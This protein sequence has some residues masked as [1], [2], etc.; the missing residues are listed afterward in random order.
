MTSVVGGLDVAFSNDYMALVLVEQGNDGK[1]RLKHLDMWRQFDWQDWKHSM[2]AKMEKYFIYKIY[3]DKTNNQS[4]TF[5]LDELGIPVHGV[6]F[7]SGAK[8]DMIRNVIK[9]INTE[10]LIMPKVETIS[11]PKQKRLVQELKKQIAEQEYV[12][13][14]SRPHLAHPPRSHDDLLWALCLALYGLEQ[15]GQ[16]IPLVWSG[17]Y[18]DQIG[19]QPGDLNSLLGMIPLGVTVTDIKIKMPWEL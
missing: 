5:S 12:H 17:D 2:V 13:N 1:I 6:T 10:K 9:L 8:Y 11:S 18:G 3:V 7:S 16:S 15:Y 4:V 19:A 14:T